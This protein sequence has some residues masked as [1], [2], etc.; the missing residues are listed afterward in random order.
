MIQFK[1]LILRRGATILLDQVNLTITP[2]Q[3]VG[4]IGANG[5]GK[6][7][8]FALLLDQLHPDQGDLSLPPHWT[9]AHVAQE[10][11]ALPISA[12]TYVLDG[13]RE[14]RR[15]EAALATAEA[16][17]AGE[18]IGHL[19]EELLRIDAWS[20]PARAARLLDGLGFS[21]SIQ[22]R[23]VSSFSGGWRMRLNLAQALMCRSDLLLLDE[24]TNHLDLEAVL[25]LEQWLANY[26]GTL[27]LI[28]HDREFLDA[29][30]SH[31]VELAQNQLTAY[32]GN[33]SQ[34]EGQR[35][36]RL[37]QQQAVFEKQQRQVAHL[38]SFISRFRAKAS[39]A[40]QA[41]SRI[42]AL[43]RLERVAA[44]HVDSPFSFSF[45]A[46]DHSPNPLLTLDDISLGYTDTPILTQIS[47]SLEAGARIGLLGP[48]GAGKS[49]LIKLLAGE[50]A[51]KRGKMTTARELKIGYFAQHQLDTLR[52][53]ESALAHLQRLTPRTREL[54]LRS[55]LGGFNF[56]GE[57]AMTPVGNFS[58]GEKSRLAL[59]LIVWQRPNLLLLDEPTNHLDL[60]MRT[61][62]TLAL[63]DFS[64]AVVIVS[65]DRALLNATTDCYWLVD[66]GHMQLFDGD[67]DDYRSYR[68][69]TQA[70][71]SHSASNHEG[72]DRKAQKRQEAQARQQ[73]AQQRKPL[74]AALTR[75]ERE[76]AALNTEKTQ[77]E[78]TLADSTLYA[79]EQKSTLQKILERQ[80]EICARLQEVEVQWLEQQMALDSLGDQDGG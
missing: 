75:S 29:S 59:A 71:A 79:P 12:L 48:N 28:S 32:T 55:W 57:H 35:A 66:R 52:P 7:S 49:T 61:A 58:G 43:E 80:G 60:D 25:W 45:D 62:L 46:P 50:L 23:P 34:F 31:I 19:H 68:L 13:D 74:I 64:G 77:L 14:L 63:Q 17:H 38:E 18:E 15:L 33:Y 26:A 78:H 21:E 41:Q 51:P 65:H 70:S 3:R 27:L 53:D 6:S 11:P 44:A 56:V 40:R 67:L 42:K 39:K 69:N 20:A 73:L 9:L 1:N 8:L 24:P 10:T 30:C 36:E 76:L 2:G 22:H 5:S 72:L 47:A 37:A 16:Q 4:L 54:E